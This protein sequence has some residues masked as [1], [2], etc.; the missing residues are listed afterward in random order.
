[1]YRH[2]DQRPVYLNLLQFRFPLNAWLSIGHRL[3]GVA[4]VLCLLCYL[5]LLHLVLLHDSVTPATVHNHPIIN[6][7]HTVFWI[8]LSYH[9]LSGTRHL[10]AEHC[11]Q[12]RYYQA[13]NS[14]T[15]SLGLLG[16][17]LALMPFII[18]QAW[19]L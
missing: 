14:R 2:P 7:L 3:S 9:W 6:T 19:S 16:A 5:A 10:C 12:P 1:M 11:T 18:H 13:I 15:T 8:S 4:L 17:W